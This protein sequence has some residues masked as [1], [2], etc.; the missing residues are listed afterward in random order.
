MKRTAW[1]GVL[2]GVALGWSGWS[3]HA[4]ED[5]KGT[6]VTIGGLTAVAPA[7]WKEEKV[8][9]ALRKFR[10]KQFKLPKTGEDKRDA[11]LIISFLG[12]DVDPMVK[13]NIKRWKAVFIPPKGKKIDD[14]AKLD[15][16]KVGKVQVTY[17]DISGTYKFNKAPFNPDSKPELL[18]DHRMIGVVFESEKGPYY[19]RLVGPAKT[20]AHH[21]KGFDS[22]LKSFK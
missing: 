18:P 13:E 7:D 16:F 19:F 9:A 14:V 4:A 5:K 2:L 22:F 12:E 8:P 10:V 11:E 1:W 20:L 15:K 6:K 21:K 17:L 3:G